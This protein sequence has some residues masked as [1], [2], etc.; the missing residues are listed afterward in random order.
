MTPI[1]G[2]GLVHHMGIVDDQTREAN[3]GGSK[4]HGYAVIIVG[5]DDGRVLADGYP[6]SVPRNGIV[7]INLEDIAQFHQ[8][9]AQCLNAVSERTPVMRNERSNRHISTA[10]EGTRS[11]V[12]AMSA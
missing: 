3:S 1:C 11:G 5:I 4:S 10:H 2:V 9:R 7:T 8:F 12:D 6:F